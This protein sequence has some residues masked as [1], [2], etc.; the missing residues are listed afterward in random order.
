MARD[1]VA[2]DGAFRRFLFAAI[3]LNLVTWR[4]AFNLGA[5]GQVFYEDVYAVVVASLAALVA[6]FFA[7][8]GS[9]PRRW[10]SRLLL[11]APTAWFIASVAFTDS[12]SDAD[13]HLGLGITG[14]IVGLTSFPY[15]LFLLARAFIP[16]LG[17]VRS[18]KRWVALGLLTVAVAVAGVLVGSHNYRFMTCFDF[19]VSGNDQPANCL[20]P[21]R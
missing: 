7:P 4:V 20:G 19:K 9:A 1:G 13:Q 2:D 5:F 3:V 21:R 18:I 12:L 10:W 17:E 16:Q 15:T 6:T 11:I 14:L 8:R